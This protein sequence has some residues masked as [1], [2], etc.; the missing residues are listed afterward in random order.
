M[1]RGGKREKAGRKKGTGR[2]GEETTVMRVPKS[3]LQEIQMILNFPLKPKAVTPFTKAS[4]VFKADF[5][6]FMPQT[7]YATT[8]AAGLP[9]PTDAYSEGRLDLNTH[10]LRNPEA[11]F[12]VRVS[13]ESMLHAGIHPG[14]L[15]IVDRSLR[16]TNGKI[17][18]AVVDGDLTVKR[19]FK[20]DKKLL[21]MP[22]NPEYASIEI[23]P[24]MHF[25][26]WGVVTNVIHPV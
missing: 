9:M 20:E 16:P 12:F 19:L 6:T 14:D 13:G 15:L 22:D 26:I 17:I 2:Y 5:T 18:I 21:L 3:R 4:D 23:T 10:L 25:M 11:T 8:V 1:G 7:M 24:D